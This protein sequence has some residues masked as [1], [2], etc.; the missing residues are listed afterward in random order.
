MTV[1]SLKWFER[2]QHELNRD[3]EYLALGRWLLGPVLLKIG[4]TPF[5]VYFHKGR[6]IE[7]ERSAALTGAEFAIVGPEEEWGRL[8][9]GEIDLGLALTPPAGRLRLEGNVIKAAGN[10][11][12]LFH[13]CRKM[14]SIPDVE[15][16]S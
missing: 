2:L 5:T 8:I 6:V 16:A 15:A 1:P 11:R 4:E 12:P 10:M 3:E 7:V 9:R 13:F 14:S